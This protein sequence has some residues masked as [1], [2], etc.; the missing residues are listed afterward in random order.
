MTQG[1]SRRDFMGTVG[2]SLLLA[3]AA[4]NARAAAGKLKVCIFSKHLQFVQGEALVRT[5]ADIGFDGIDITVRKGG[6]VEPGRVREDLPRLV[7]TIRA[8]NL[9]VPMVTTDIVDATTPFAADVLATLQDLGIRNY[10]WGGLKYTAGEP[11]AAQLTAFRPRI[12]KL[13]ELNLR[14][15]TCAMYHTHSGV[16][17][18]GAP[19]W[20]LHILLDGLDPAAIG[21]N[22]DIGH[23]TIEGGVGGWIESFNI[24]GRYLH[25]IAVK[26]LVWGRNAR[27]G[28]QPQ[29]V[30]L[31]EG[32]VRL[33]AFFT[34][35]AK[36][37]FSGPLQMH[38]EYELGDP[39]Q[40]A[41]AMKRDLAK[42]RG[43][44][45]QAGV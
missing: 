35:V 8:G 42:L 23:A 30:P 18:V 43:L 3:G 20:D 13:A 22:Y 16:G 5:A 25:G 19:I 27:G 6:H 17:L 28:W 37:G 38:F 10:R 21:V 4:E 7:R 32:M 12:A 24:T 15:K 2:G 34:M 39:A 41:F 33:P 40:T 29:W 9:E 31:G 45:A 26:D 1:A 36:A 11:I 14:Y 44:L